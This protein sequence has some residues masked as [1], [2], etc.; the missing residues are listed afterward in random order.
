MLSIN[1]HKVTREG[2][3][4]CEPSAW[5][6]NM[7]TSK[8]S[9]HSRVKEKPVQDDTGPR[10]FVKNRQFMTETLLK[11]KKLSPEFQQCYPTFLYF[12][13]EHPALLQP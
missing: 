13:T 11:M 12:K 6:A 9:T 7:K 3:A 2:R 5:L 8:Q 10:N 4:E 1:S